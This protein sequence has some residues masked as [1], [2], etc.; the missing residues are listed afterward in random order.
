MTIDLFDLLD[1]W[2]LQVTDEGYPYA[3]VLEVLEEY[4]AVAFALEDDEE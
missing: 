1:D 2:V 4:V 3:H